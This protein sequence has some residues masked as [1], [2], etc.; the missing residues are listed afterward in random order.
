MRSSEHILYPL[1]RNS[2]KLLSQKPQLVDH[3][4]VLQ[5]DFRDRDQV[6]TPLPRREGFKSSPQFYCLGIHP[7]Y[8]EPPPGSV[9][10]PLSTSLLLGG[11]QSEHQIHFPFWIFPGPPISLSVQKYHKFLAAMFPPSLPQLTTSKPFPHC[12]I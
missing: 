2:I 10:L 3:V 12:T 5:I 1:T 8:R 9:C 7:P 6:H 4:R 11:Y